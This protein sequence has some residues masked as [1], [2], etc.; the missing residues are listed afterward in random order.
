MVADDASLFT[1]VVTL[2]IVKGI[3]VGLGDLHADQDFVVGVV[4]P[5][6]VLHFKK[7]VEHTSQS[8]HFVD[9]L[10]LSHVFVL[11]TLSMVVRAQHFP[12]IVADDAPS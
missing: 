5:L 1:H 3:Q 12:D 9:G 8:L 4:L 2:I 10:E 11:L 6:H 7:V